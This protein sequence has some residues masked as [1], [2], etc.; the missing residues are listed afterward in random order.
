MTAAVRKLLED[1]LA[2]PDEDRR[3]IAEALLD[4]MP[5]ETLDEIEDAWEEAARQRAGRL[6][7]GEVQARDG[8][9]VVAELQAK[10]QT[11]RAS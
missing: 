10:L 3:Q 6:E 7:R 11:T 5:P 8:D 9:E 1:V 2:L 4:T